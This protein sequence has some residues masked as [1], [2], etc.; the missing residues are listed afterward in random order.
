MILNILPGALLLL[1]APDSTQSKPAFERRLDEASVALSEI[2]AAPDKGIP[3]DLLSKAEC[4]VIVPGLKKAAFI[5]GGQ[6]GK[7]FV[8]C[9]RR[10]GGRHRGPFALKA[11][12]SDCKSAVPRRML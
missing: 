2:M 8:S 1:A 3:G 11:G 10:A 5:F 9:R 6:Y 4:V 7:G 12:P